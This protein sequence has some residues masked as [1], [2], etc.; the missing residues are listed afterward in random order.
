MAKKTT[1]TKKSSAAT[2]AGFAAILGAPNVGKSTLLNHL[3]GEKVS[4]VSSK[5][6]TTRMRVL[7]L[8]TEDNT[9]IALIDTPGIFAPRD[10]LDKAMVRAA[11]QSLEGADAV[12]LMVDAT[13][14][15]P[16]SKTEVIIEA[17]Q[18]RKQQA[19]LV[20]NKVDKAKRLKLLPLAE[21]LSKTG[22]FDKIFMISALTGDGVDDLKKHLK[23]KMPK[24]PWL[25]PADQLTDLP[26]RLWAAEITREQIFRQLSDELPYAAAVL[27]STWENRKDGSTVIHQTIIVMR[28]NHRAIVLGKKGSRIKAIG[29]ASREEMKLWLKRKVHLFLDV[30]AD[31]KWQDKSEFYR[32]FGLEETK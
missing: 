16:D 12:L 19:T 26:E 31:E 3:V 28:P 9:Q 29:Q 30:K 1:V 10:R 6:Q 17:L 22:V 4:I 24:E 20:L 11:W 2:H 14:R 7:G 21:H 15:Q 8:L 23:A 25:F 27:P 5:A 32:V 13:A 18:S